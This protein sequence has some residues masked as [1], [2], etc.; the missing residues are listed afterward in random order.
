MNTSPLIESVRD[1]FPDAVLAS[2][3]YRGDETVV[4]RRE[5][6]LEVTRFLKEEPALRMNFLMDLSAVDYSTFGKSPATAFFASSGVALSPSS[7]I[8]DEDPWPGPPGKARF[9]VV[10]HFY[11]LQHKHR[12]PAGG[13]PGGGRA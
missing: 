5:F 12:P 3:T 1:R 11:S 6:L 13:P 4:L 8:P 10:Y 7:Q 2:H 9:A